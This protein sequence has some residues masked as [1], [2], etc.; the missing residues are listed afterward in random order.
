MVLV[1]MAVA[2][3]VWDV[4]VVLR[5]IRLVALA[6]RLVTA[7]VLLTRLPVATLDLRVVRVSPVVLDRE[8]RVPFVVVVVP[9]SL[10]SVIALDVPVVVVEVVV[11][12]IPL[13]TALTW[14]SMFRV[15]CAMSLYVVM[16]L[17]DRLRAPGLML[18]SFE[19]LVDLP[20]GILMHC[21]TLF[22]MS[23]DVSYVY[24]AAEGTILVAVLFVASSMARVIGRWTVLVIAMC[25]A[26]MRSMSLL[27]LCFLVLARRK[28]INATSVFLPQG[29]WRCRR[30]RCL[31][32]GSGEDEGGGA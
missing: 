6:S 8:D 7:P 26:G 29:L 13:L 3:V 17:E 20:L 1:P 9:V 10:R 21:M 32:L 31:R 25:S 4:A 19:H 2:R 15:V 14:L 5:P 24:R 30:R 22:V 12:R 23:L 27:R 28:R 18:V 16:A 11:D